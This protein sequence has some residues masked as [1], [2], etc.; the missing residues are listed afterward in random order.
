MK[1]VQHER[2]IHL[3]VLDYLR[4][5]FPRGLVMHAANEIGLSGKDVARQ[6]AHAKHLGMVPGFPDLAVFTG[7]PESGG[8]TLLF[9]VKAAGG[10]HS[11]A[12]KAVHEALRANGF[13]VAVVRSVQDVEEVLEHWFGDLP[14]AWGA[15]GL[16]LIVFAGLGLRL[17]ALR[18]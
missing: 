4:L 17:L 15:A 1:R 12:Q 9:E 3:A 11:P 10:C 18:R 6:I 8:E 5:R 14:D 7:D 16:V 13:R 2:T